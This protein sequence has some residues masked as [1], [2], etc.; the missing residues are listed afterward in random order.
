MT[1]VLSTVGILVFVLLVLAASSVRMVQ[2]YERGVVLRF[3]RLLPEVRQPGLR[4]VEMDIRDVEEFHVTVPDRC[5]PA[6]LGKAST[7]RYHAA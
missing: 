5:R 1:A 2:Q 4:A 6:A 7:G 3:G